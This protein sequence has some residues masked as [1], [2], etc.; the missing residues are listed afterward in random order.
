MRKKMKIS[1]LS[2]AFF[3]TIAAYGITLLC[4]QSLL[5]K[6]FSATCFDSP[7]V[8]AFPEI[9]YTML[10]LFIFSLIA[11]TPFFIACFIWRNSILAHKKLLLLIAAFGPILLMLFAYI[12]ITHSAPQIHGDE[13]LYLLAVPCASLLG[14]YAMFYTLSKCAQPHA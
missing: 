9:A 4:L 1:R 12:L 5:C 3:V 13:W 2:A 11:N 8:F 14:G 10:G 7:V 6:I